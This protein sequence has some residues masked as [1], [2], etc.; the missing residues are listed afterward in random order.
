MHFLGIEIGHTMTRVVALDVETAKVV[1]SASAGHGWIEGL[2]DG[3]AEQ[4][5]GDWLKGVDEAVSAVMQELGEARRAVAGIGVTAPDGG[6]VV[7]D[8]DDRV[9]R[10]AK[11]GCDTSAT[12]EV[13]AIGKAFG[14]A[15]G[16]IELIGNPP[17]A[18]SMAA[19]LLWLKEHE[20]RHF[21]QAARV[22]TVQDF[23]GYW[24]TGEGGSSASTAAT[25]GLFAVP[26]RSWCQDM[27][28]LIDPAVS[29]MLPA[30]LS[31]TKPRGLLRP[32]LAAK[33]GL[34]QRVI[35]APGL[36]SR[37][38]ALFALGIA[39]PREVV[40]DLSADGSL[41]ALSEDPAIDFLGEGEVGCDVV[42][43]GFTRME[44]RNVV[45]APEMVRR[46]Y[47]WSMA[48]FEKHLAGAPVGADGLLFLPYLRGESV[49]RMPDAHGVLH[50]I[51]LNN[52]TPGN[53]ARA[54]A[55]GVALGFG[56]AMS[57]LRDVGIE[58]TELRLTRD[59]GAAGGALLAD[60]CGL[61]VVTVSG[62]G[63]A[64]LGAAMQAA[65]VFFHEQG[66]KLGFDEIAGYVVFV[67][68]DSRRQPD[69][70]RQAF[71]EELLAKQQYLAE[72]LHGGGF[73]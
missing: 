49:P 56:Y 15:P 26:E 12:R 14:G 13:E 64:I 48:E 66:E 24:L 50:G 6:M 3:F 16:V 33:W 46:H 8:G 9:V 40:A 63:G 27:V 30:G 54:A 10:P 55:E 52:F 17:E 65:A 45:A 21:A 29:G 44:L 1:A 58:P 37:A 22:L 39:N 61:P 51:T 31:A 35:V 20:P 4:Q 2:P 68:E 59:P 62:G 53:L 70:G 34:D 42:G 60:V 25:T 41:T 73:L 69:P 32:A 7:M 67:D 36:G 18:G 5:P 71:Y 57:R 72:T 43:N 38:A 28:D 47:G 11:L 19:Q 23:I